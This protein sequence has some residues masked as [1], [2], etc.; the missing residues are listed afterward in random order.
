MYKIPIFHSLVDLIP[1]KIKA[2]NFIEQ[3]ER[4][5]MLLLYDTLNSLEVS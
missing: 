5:K 4:E 1:T 2:Q 3:Q